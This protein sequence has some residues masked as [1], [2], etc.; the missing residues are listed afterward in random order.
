MQTLGWGPHPVK[1]VSSYRRMEILT[2][3]ESHAATEAEIGMMQVPVKEQRQGKSL[4]RVP[5]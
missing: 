5:H 1:L 4:P 3:R 2:Q